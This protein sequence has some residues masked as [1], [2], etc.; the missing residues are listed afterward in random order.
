MNQPG[1][2]SLRKV[3]RCIRSLNASSRR[4]S[5]LRGKEPNVS[6]SFKAWVHFQKDYIPSIV[7]LH[8][9]Q[10]SQMSQHTTHHSR[11][12]R[13]A[14]Q[15]DEASQPFLL[16]HLKLLRYFLS[17]LWVLVSRHPVHSPS[18]ETD[19]TQ[20]YPIRPIGSF[21]VCNPH[22][23]HLRFGVSVG[24]RISSYSRLICGVCLAYIGCD[25]AEATSFTAGLA[26]GG[27]NSLI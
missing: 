10:T 14:L 25:H 15:E 4:V 9:S 3:N 21:A 26:G 20:G 24:V 12:T 17:R 2:A 23:I 8:A 27:K 13:H 6:I 19:G 16:R 1:S 22:V 18:E 5:I 7:T 11:H